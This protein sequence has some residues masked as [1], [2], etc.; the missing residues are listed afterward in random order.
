M[1]CMPQKKFA[2]N[3]PACFDEFGLKAELFS[4]IARVLSLSSI[5]I[6]KQT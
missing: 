6:L 1:V 5:G 2:V 4:Y 3:L